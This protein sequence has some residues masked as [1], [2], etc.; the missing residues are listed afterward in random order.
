MVGKW[1]HFGKKV[2]VS[3]L[4]RDLLTVRMQWDGISLNTNRG[5]FA[6]DHLL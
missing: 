6:R 2:S 5:F 3:L 4:C 1:F